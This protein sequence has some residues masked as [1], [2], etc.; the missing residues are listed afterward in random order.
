MKFGKLHDVSQVDFSH[1]EDDN[2]NGEVLTKFGIK[3]EDQKLYIGTTSWGVKEWKGTLYPI[4]AKATDF[5]QYYSQQ[6][7]S[8]ELNTTHYGIPKIET[9]KKWKD[10]SI[11][12]FMFC[13]K[14]LQTI[15]HSKDLAVSTDRLGYF[16][17]ALSHLEH[18]LGICFLQLPPYFKE[19]RLNRLNTFLDSIPNHIRLAVEF[20]NENLFSNGIKPELYDILSKHGISAVIT[21]VAGR[22]DVLHSSIL[23]D[24][25]V[26][27]FV[28]NDD[29]SDWERLE[30]WMERLKKI[31][32]NWA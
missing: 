31:G 29:P 12:D 22:R 8:I 6:F 23:S 17:D 9:I 18:K 10:N 7:N 21:D 3:T 13:P 1:P 28:A 15:S 26:I 11:E 32:W 16:I 19:D 30:W 27:R 5:L 20:R 14:V 2:R 4:K 25:V 24:H